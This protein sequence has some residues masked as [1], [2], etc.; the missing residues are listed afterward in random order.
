MGCIQC[1]NAISA[2]VNRSTG[3][4]LK[5]HEGEEGECVEAASTGAS[6]RMET[7]HKHG[8]DWLPDSDGKCAEANETYLDPDGASSP[9]KQL[10]LI[11]PF[12]G[13]L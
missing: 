3:G 9:H 10:S 5:N 2:V 13:L 8:N 7:V 11:Y 6:T 4:E 12:C 1:K